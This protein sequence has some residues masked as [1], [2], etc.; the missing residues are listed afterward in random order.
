MPACF[1]PFVC[2]AAGEGIWFE[3]VL[4]GVV[5]TTLE[6]QFLHLASPLAVCYVCYALLCCVRKFKVLKLAFLDLSARR[7]VVVAVAKVGNGFIIII[8]F[9]AC[10]VFRTSLAALRWMS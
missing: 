7:G 8:F 5:I 6:T 10:F 9:P 2:S 4:A 3:C 1:L